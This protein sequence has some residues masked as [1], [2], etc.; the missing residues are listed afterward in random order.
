MAYPIAAMNRIP[1]ADNCLVRTRDT[2]RQAKIKDSG[3][4]SQNV[5]GAFQVHGEWDVTGLSVLLIDDVATSGSTLHEAAMALYASGAGK[6][7][8]AA[9]AGNRS[10]RNAEPF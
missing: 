7:L 4:R 6:V 1:F 5:A 2:M 10:I 3:E 9:F 8:C